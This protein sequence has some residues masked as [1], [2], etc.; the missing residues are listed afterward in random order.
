MG[1][2]AE[3][4]EVTKASPFCKASL[5][6]TLVQ[7]LLTSP[8]KP[9][10]ESHFKHQGHCLRLCH[11]PLLL[12]WEARSQH[13]IF[14]VGLPGLT[15]LFDSLVYSNYLDLKHLTCRKDANGGLMKTSVIHVTVSWV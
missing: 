10:L 6:M 4:R 8:D 7:E 5:V 3:H 14:S 1:C 11:L 12:P 2:G 9:S 13:G 15:H